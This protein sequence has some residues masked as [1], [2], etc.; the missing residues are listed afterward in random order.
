MSFLLGVVFLAV[1]GVVT[2]QATWD[3]VV[4][5]TSVTQ[6][7]DDRPRMM[8]GKFGEIDVTKEA[9]IAFFQ[10]NEDVRQLWGLRGDERFVFNRVNNYK[11]EIFTFRFDQVLN[12][13][14]VFG[15]EIAIHVASSGLIHGFSGNVIPSDSV[16]EPSESIKL[17]NKVL[18]ST[19]KRFG[20]HHVKPLGT[21][22]LMYAVDVED[23]G[24]LVWKFPILSD[25]ENNFIGDHPFAPKQKA[26]E[27]FDVYIDAVSHELVMDI[28]RYLK[29]LNRYVYTSE[30]TT[31]LPGFGP[32]RSEGDPPNSDETVNQAYDNAGNCYNYYWDL[33]DRD[34]WDGMGADINSSVHFMVDYDNAFWNGEQMV[35]GDGDGVIFSDFANDLAVICHEL[36]HAVTQTTSGLIYYYESGALNEGFSDIMGSSAVVYTQDKLNRLDTG[37][38]WNIGSNV[39]LVQLNPEGC[40]DCPVAT[41]YMNNPPQDGNSRDYYPDRYT[42]LQDNRGVHS[43]SG[44]ANLAYVLTVQGGVQPQLQED[45]YVIPLGIQMAEQIYYLAFTQFLTSTSKFIDARTATIKAADV[46]Y[47]GN[48]LANDSTANAW[49]AVGVI[50]T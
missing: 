40:P 24:R 31:N 11:K 25:K 48:N 37:A 47:P 32:V 12:G 2:P 43:N 16:S 33:Y 21:A 28:P 3:G 39:T 35:Y 34:S 4:E 44:I 5:V 45:V 50:P 26:L 42:G 23:M 6:T 7:S 38:A 22:E 19:L 27:P 36:T 18:L 10:H 13:L 17:D 46:L 30:N 14:P 20:H 15:G 8:F 9:A 49:T 29:A 1:V 41:R